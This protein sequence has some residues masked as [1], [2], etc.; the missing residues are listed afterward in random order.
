MF[1]VVYLHGTSSTLEGPTHFSFKLKFPYNPELFPHNVHNHLG[2]FR[3]SFF[4]KNMLEISG[5][6]GTV[7]EV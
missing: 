3:K 6:Q 7:K 2:S 5:W 4:L 1:S